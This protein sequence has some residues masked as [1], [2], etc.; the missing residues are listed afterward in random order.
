[1]RLYLGVNLV[2]LLS[3]FRVLAR[4]FEP[5]PSPAP[6]PDAGTSVKRSTMQLDRRRSL[7]MGF[8]G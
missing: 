3:A 5:K 7:T 1:M 4:S 8:L 6:L 2:A